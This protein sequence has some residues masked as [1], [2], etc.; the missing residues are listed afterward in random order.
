MKKKMTLV[1]SIVDLVS[2]IG[3]YYIVG[4]HSIFLYVLSLS[5]YNVFISCFDHL[6]IKEY[7]KKIKATKSKQKIFKYLLLVIAIVS[8][9]FLLISILFSDL[10]GIFL[11][12]SDLL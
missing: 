12:I 8:F 5:L 2:I 6:S 4:S 10:I 3:L 1:F 7:F 9:I 11:K